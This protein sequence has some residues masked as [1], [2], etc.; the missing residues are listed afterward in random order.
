MAA[1]SGRFMNRPLKWRMTLLMNGTANRAR[2]AFGGV[3]GDA[4]GEGLG[5]G[6]RVD[7][8]EGEDLVAIGEKEVQVAL[9]FVVPGIDQ[10]VLAQGGGREVG[11]VRELDV[12]GPRSKRSFL[13]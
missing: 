2:S 9:G 8:H 10:S 3:E 5:G 1:A 11:E 6:V 7:S 12:F 13:P 4:Q